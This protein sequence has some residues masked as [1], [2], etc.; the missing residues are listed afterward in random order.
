MVVLALAPIAVAAVLL[1]WAIGGRGSSDVA[2]ADPQGQALVQQLEDGAYALWA[3]NADGSAVRWNA[4]E[5]IRWV[6]NP[7]G[8]PLGAVQEL[9][10]AMG[11]VTEGTG[12]TFDYLGETDE[13]PSRD[14]RP[15]QP[16][17]YDAQ[18][19]A[20]VLISW[21]TPETT[22]APLT[23]NDRAVAVPVAVGDADERAFV[24][25]QVIFN[26]ELAGIPGFTDRRRSIGITMLH[27]LL[28]VVG[29]GHVD[30][31]GEIMFPFPVSGIAGFGNGDV[32][33]MA[34]IG[35]QQPCLA[36]PEPEDIEVSYAQ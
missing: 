10:V 4:C 9:Q 2:V 32:A 25:A 26:R 36:T 11:R 22:D 16:E 15:Y 28:H 30:D 35:V 34:E 8:A 3:R 20:P 13:L 5:P 24:T 19:W 27:E 21:R 23:E 1:G 18:H 33:G 17:R 31:T 12:L 29:L 14:R 7:D 6:F